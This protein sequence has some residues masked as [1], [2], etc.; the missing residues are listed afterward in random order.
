MALAP[1]M[2]RDVLPEF[3]PTT[4]EVQTEAAGLSASEVEQMLTVPL[5]ADLL[6]GVPWLAT[7]RS[8]SVPGLSSITLVFE[9]GT[10]PLRARQ[11][12]NERVT[13]A[14]ALPNVS[15]PPIML[16][17]QSSTSRVL[18]VVGRADDD[19]PGR[20]LAYWPATPSGPG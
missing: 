6:N 12:V 1:D 20:R 13:Q 5:E 15:A 17:P 10:D 8:E 16:E 18:A 2:S 7:L 9:P 11:M 3:S 4:V 19:V 14:K